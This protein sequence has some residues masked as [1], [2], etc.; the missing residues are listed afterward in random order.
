MTILDEN[1]DVSNLFIPT[2]AIYQAF[3]F[4]HLNCLTG[5]SAN[6]P[7]L[8]P[9]LPNIPVTMVY[10]PYS[11]L[12]SSQFSSMKTSRTPYGPQHKMLRLQNHFTCMTPLINCLN[13]ILESRQPELF[14]LTQHPSISSS[15]FFFNEP[16]VDACL[17]QITQGMLRQ[18]KPAN[19]HNNVGKS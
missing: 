3:I 6:I 10:L 12:L 9:F 7:I 5:L 8:V 2:A 1:Q 16:L 11:L 15:S 4:S 19:V 14:I 18:I 13:T 17:V